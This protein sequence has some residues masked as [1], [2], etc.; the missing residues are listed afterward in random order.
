[1]DNANR[2]DSNILNIATREFV[3]FFASPAASRPG[4]PGLAP[5]RS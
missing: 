4:T 5:T 3:A 2:A 1:M